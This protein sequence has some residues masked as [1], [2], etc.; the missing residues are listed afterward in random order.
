MLAVPDV[1]D[2]R[3]GIEACS[4]AFDSALDRLRRP[5]GAG[6]D[7]RPIRA[8]DAVA[9]NRLVAYPTGSVSVGEPYWLYCRSIVS[10]ILASES[11]RCSNRI[12]SRAMSTQILQPNAW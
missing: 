2:G 7:R 3:V 9:T 1:S 4:L 10:R 8:T 5:N 12:A 11:P 6:N